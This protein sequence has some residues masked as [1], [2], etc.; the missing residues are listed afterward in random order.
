MQ[1]YQR[2]TMDEAREFVLDLC[3]TEKPACLSQ[4]RTLLRASRHAGQFDRLNLAMLQLIDARRL[5]VNL[6]Y[7]FVW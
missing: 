5:R 3:Q 1:T 7:R 2:L 6:S 4:A